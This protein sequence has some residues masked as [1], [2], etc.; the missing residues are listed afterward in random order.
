MPDVTVKQLAET[1]GTP[2]DRL[3]QQMQEAD[4]PQLAEAEM[5]SEGQKEQLL[6]FLKKIH[7][8]TDGQ[9]KKITLK[10]RTLST[11][12][13]GSGAAR[14]RTV[15]VEVRK[16]RTYVQRGVAEPEEG[17]QEV[18]PKVTDVAEVIPPSDPEAEKKAE[19]AARRREAHAELDAE[20]AKRRDE[21]ARKV[22]EEKA[23]EEAEKKSQESAAQ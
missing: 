5:V 20:A 15:N 16:K 11:L 21:A 22:E 23:K 1:I 8:E 4:L 10:R 3:L 9:P 13:A 18:E 2:V 17:Q 19:E 14:G 12:K 7:G 6:S